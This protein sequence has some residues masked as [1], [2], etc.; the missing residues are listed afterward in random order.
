MLDLWL[1]LSAISGAALALGCVEPASDDGAATSGAGLS[2]G[3]TGQGAS[4][5]AGGA[6]GGSGGM[7]GAPPGKVPVFIAQGSVGRTAI[8]CDDGKTWVGDHAWDTDADPM[9][10]GMAQQAVC[11][12]SMCSYQVG[13]ECVQQ[14]CCDHSAD[15]AKG[16]VWGNGQFVATWGWGQPGVVRTSDNGI[17]WVTTH[18][19]DTFGGLAFG[20]GRFVLA[21]RSPF[22]SEDGLEWTAGG[23]ADFLNEDGST[24]WS[25]RRFA[26]ADYDGGG[27]FVAV[28][29]GDSSRD[30]LVSSDGGETWWRPSVIPSDCAGEVSTYGGIVSGDGVIVIVDMAGNACRSTDGGDTWSVTPTGLEQVLSHGVWT[31]SEFWFW[32]DDS[33]LARS[34]D[35]AT[36]TTTPMATPKRLGPVARS[37]DGTLVAVASVW[38]GYEAQ[39]F[40]R[41]TD[42]LT[43]ES[44]PAGA[45]AASHPIFYLGYGYAEPSEACPL[46]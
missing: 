5:G 27:R 39:E 12:E 32:G 14:Q 34:P 9:M 11:Y 21:S 4:G 6:T 28:A 42:G 15:V 37:D 26:Y 30:M 35:G 2:G 16:V 8:S 3:T 24:M 13:T 38:Q 45:F 31:G 19:D 40:L 44:L 22:H 17:D 18:P 43:W 20:G 25:V 1:R 41:S 23:E 33:H 7:G 29:S 46:P 36:W 10:C